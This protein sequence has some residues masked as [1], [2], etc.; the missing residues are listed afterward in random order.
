MWVAGP[1][2]LVYSRPAHVVV[3]PMLWP[4][5][6]DV[7]SLHGEVREGGE[8]VHIDVM[9]VGEVGAV[10]DVEHCPLNNSRLSGVVGARELVQG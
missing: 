10:Q 1:E 6:L 2:H 5:A 4:R 8:R 3:E 9:E 7:L